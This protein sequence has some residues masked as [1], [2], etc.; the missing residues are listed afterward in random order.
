MSLFQIL[1]V[2]YER[3]T[4]IYD[5]INDKEQRVMCQIRFRCA[6]SHVNP[7]SK[8]YSGEGVKKYYSRKCN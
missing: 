3:K 6:F 7:Q 8:T 5:L 2:I 1:T 4:M